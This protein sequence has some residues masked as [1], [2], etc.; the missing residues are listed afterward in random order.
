MPQCQFPI[1]CCF[2]VLQKLHKKY[3][4]NWTKQKP[5]FLF[6]LTQDGVQRRDGGE[7]WASHAIGRRGLAL[8]RATRLWS[9]LANLL[10]PP[11]HL[12]ILLGEK[13]LRTQSIFHKTYCKPPA[14]ST[15]DR[16]GPEALPG[17]LLERRITIGG[18]IRHHVCLRS[19][20]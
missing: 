12:Y 3:S 1:F 2:C 7:P 16:E 8:G 6:F 10:T 4:R 18:L 5:K 15:Q 20:V 19:D 14:S 11:F 13:T 17:T 9:H